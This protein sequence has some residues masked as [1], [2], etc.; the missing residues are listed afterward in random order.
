M[1]ANM[2]REM[3]SELGCDEGGSERPARLVKRARATAGWPPAWASDRIVEC[4]DCGQRRLVEGAERAEQ[5]RLV[6]ETEAR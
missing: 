4:R 2:K 6:A 1:D 5:N 3:E